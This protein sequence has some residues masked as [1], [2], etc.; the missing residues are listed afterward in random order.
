MPS[1][2]FQK[3]LSYVTSLI[4]PPTPVRMFQ[5]AFPYLS[6]IAHLGTL[7]QA[8]RTDLSY[9]LAKAFTQDCAFPYSFHL[10][11]IPSAQ[12]IRTL[13]G[14]RDQGLITLQNR[15]QVLT[16]HSLGTL[17]PYLGDKVIPQTME[18]WLSVF[19]AYY[20]HVFHKI[21]VQSTLTQGIYHTTTS[22][23]KGYTRFLN[24]LYSQ[25]HARGLLYQ[26]IKELVVCDSCHIVLGD[27]ERSHGAGLGVVYSHTRHAPPAKGAYVIDALGAG[28]R[29]THDTPACPQGPITSISGGVWCRCGGQA[30]LQRAP[31]LFLRVDE[32]WKSKALA[33]LQATRVSDRAVKPIIAAAIQNMRDYNF[34]RSAT[35][36]LGSTLDILKG[37]PYQGMIVDP[38]GDSMVHTWYAATLFQPRP[39]HTLSGL[40]S[41]KEVPA[42]YFTSVDL[43][44]NHVPFMVLVHALFDRPMPALAINGF[45]LGADAQKMSKSVGNVITWQTL[46]QA[47]VVGADLRFFIAQLAD[48][49]ESTKVAIPD[50]LRAGVTGKRHASRLRLALQEKHVTNKTLDV[51]QRIRMTCRPWQKPSSEKAIALRQVGHLLFHEVRASLGEKDEGNDKKKT[52]IS[53]LIDAYIPSTTPA[54]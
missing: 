19:V 27:H 33:L 37:G 44:Q 4:R 49:T 7:S 13:N 8:I 52:L 25:F 1:R 23:D 16:R 9:R 5:T 14:L 53:R 22:I 46:E 39:D 6:G 15:E 47:G 28:Y 26:G 20:R 50:I 45:L 35:H 29:I 43:L 32:A 18:G 12:K 31:A 36:A 21:G 10:T 2:T 40:L 41:S 30:Q 24:E 42:V 34:L 3:A 38:I 17:T 48:T 51:L 54:L 11:G